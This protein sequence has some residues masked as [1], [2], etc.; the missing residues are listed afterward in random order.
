[1]KVRILSFSA[2][3]MFS[4]L[5]EDS[6]CL[7][8]PTKLLMNKL[9]N[10]WNEVIVFG[11]SLPNHTLAGPFSIV[12]KALHMISFGT[13]WRCIVVLNVVVWSQGSRF[14]SYESKVGIL[15]LEG[16]GW[17]VVRDCAP[18]PLY[19]MLGQTHVN[20]WSRVIASQNGGLTSYIFPFRLRVLQW[21]RHLFN[22]SK[23][24]KT[25]IEKNSSFY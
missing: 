22:Y 19:R 21:N 11:G 18:G 13:P 23:N 14:P 4:M 10:S 15:N 1:M 2:C 24:K 25:I 7:W 6:L 8:P 16:K 17:F 5:D 9:L 12:E 20:G 3:S